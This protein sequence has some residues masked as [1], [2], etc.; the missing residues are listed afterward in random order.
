[1]ENLLRKQL[2]VIKERAKKM[3]SRHTGREVIDDMLDSGVIVRGNHPGL[4]KV[5]TKR[6]W[7]DRFQRDP[8]APYK[9]GAPITLETAEPGEVREIDGDPY[10]LVRPVGA[11]IDPSTPDEAQS[12]G[13]LT[14]WPETVRESLRTRKRGRH[15]TPPDFNRE[16]IC[17]LDIET[18]G[19]AGN[20]YLFLCGLMFYQAGTFVVEQV[21]ARDYAEENGVLKHVQAA[22]NRFGTVVTYNGDT[23]DL[24]FI[25]T[26]FAVH[27]IASKPEFRSVDLLHTTRTAFHDVLPNRKLL[28]VE[29]HLRGVGREGDIP[30][31]YIPDA[32]HDFV[33]TGDARVIKN[34]LYHNRMDIFTMA[35]IINRLADRPAEVLL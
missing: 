28:T 18:T 17:F 1:M 8:L 13:R 3:R 6:R 15:W 26:R 23:F 31:R 22:L 12:F 21:F 2:A 20:T 9:H 30:G 10:Y 27:R 29:K 24:P 32:Y 4:R 5:E 34:V 25:S 16:D 11:A 7:Y 14:Q 33:R 19:L 35:I